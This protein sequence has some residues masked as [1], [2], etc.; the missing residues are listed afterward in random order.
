MVLTRRRRTRSWN[1]ELAL[2][3]CVQA[4]WISL[5]EAR[6]ED[7]WAAESSSELQDETQGS[8]QLSEPGLRPS[9]PPST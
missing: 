6:R 3:F 1:D 7:W 4:A 5:S 9:V 8:L 2:A